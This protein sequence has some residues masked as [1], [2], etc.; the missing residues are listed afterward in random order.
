MRLI[1]ARIQGFG[2][3]ADTKINL[4][5][6]V[7]AIVGPN[8]AG[9]TT[10]L[11][12]LARMDSDEALPIP[13]RSRAVDVTD[14]TIVTSVDFVLDDAD[15]DSVSGLGLEEAPR[16][17]TVNRLARGGV[18]IAIKPNPTKDGNVLHSWVDILTRYLADPDLSDYINPD[19]TYADP[20]SDAPRDYPAELEKLI[21]NTKALLSGDG[22]ISG[23]DQLAIDCEEL[24][25][26][27]LDAEKASELR[28]VISN[29]TEW[30]RVGNT[31]TETINILW[32][33]TPDFLLFGEDDRTLLSTYN[34]DEVLLA[35]TPP[36]LLNLASMAG[37]DLAKLFEY[38]Q[39]SNFGPRS[40]TIAQANARLNSAFKHS[41]KQS[42]L[43]VRLDI[44]GS[45]LRVMI[46]EDG[47]NITVF[48]ERSAG[49]QMFVAL[50]A[51]LNVHG[52]TRPPIL[53]IDEAENHL[54]IDAQ[55]DLVSM[56]M[57]QEQAA[58]VIYTTHSPA[59]LPPD[60]GSGIRSVVPRQDNQQI[61]DVRN[62]FWGNG[63]GFTPLMMAM[64]AAAAAFTP[65]RC[66]VLAEGATEMIMLPTLIRMATGEETLN[67]QIAPGLSESPT[68]LYPQ[69]DFEGAKVAY[70][71][72]GDAGGR[73]LKKALIRS[74]IPEKL[75]VTLAV[76]GLENTLEPSV[77]EDATRSLLAESNPGA[78]LTG[79][80]LFS[81]PKVG[82]WASKI[83]K[84]AEDRD[85]VMPSKVAIASWLVGNEKIE[86]NEEC[87]SELKSTHEALMEVLSV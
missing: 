45:Q 46:W 35:N 24:L 65:A 4:D 69:L 76:P 66:V 30:L 36:A 59:C 82:S 13:Q 39:S 12:A 25:S 50:T 8:E 34:F 54:H 57:T 86:I 16:S 63:P 23:H 74:G 41:W 52:T 37:L 47:D 33:R 38:H 2:R 67:Y 22:G 9:K 83:S 32:S 3:L 10:L 62:N 49:L 71:V 72:D 60:L 79:M 85:L 55:A 61:S 11:K 51:F 48:N 14:E 44:D 6:K 31:S 17:M 26:G 15:R 70:L 68:A 27:T 19:T 81:N 80:P 75:I 5:S 7:I 58:N 29:L 78:D 77:Y 73:S 87:A 28:L 42:R 84:W 20:N 53:L 21:E 1:K 43:S 18:T 64:G 56:F 40:T